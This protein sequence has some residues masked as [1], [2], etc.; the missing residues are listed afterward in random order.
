[1]RR[2]RGGLLLV[3]MMV[4]GLQPIPVP[5]YPQSMTVQVTDVYPVPAK[6]RALQHKKRGDEFRV[7]DDIG[8]AG[9]EYGRALSLYRGFS[10]EDRIMMYRYV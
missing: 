10:V 5:A 3:G 2:I 1:M 8:H 4:G 7:R 9:E 6:E